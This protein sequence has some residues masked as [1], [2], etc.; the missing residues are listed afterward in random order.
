MSEPSDRFLDAYERMLEFLEVQGRAF[1]AAH[2]SV[3]GRVG[4]DGGSHADPLVRW[5]IESVAF[6][7]AATV[8]ECDRAEGRIAATLLERLAPWLVEPFPACGLAT[9]R[10]REGDASIAGG[11]VLPAGTVVRTAEP[12]ADG[13]RSLFR[14]AQDL[15][16]LPLEIV[17]AEVRTSSIDVARLPG[18]R[19]PAV[20]RLR[21]RTTAD[22]PVA[23]LSA[24]RLRLHFDGGVGRR[25]HHRLAVGAGPEEARPVAGDP[26][27]GWTVVEPLAGTG[28]DDDEALVPADPRV[29][30]GHRLLREALAMPARF[31]FVE[32]RG[33]G[34]AWATVPG[35]EIELVLPLAEDDPALE[36]RTTADCVH[37]HRVPI[38]NVVRTRLEP[39]RLHDRGRAIPLRCG[40]D[41]GGEIVRVVDVVGR[42]AGRRALRF[43]RFHDDPAGRE[44]GAWYRLER[45]PA[46][47]RAT[48]DDGDGDHRL[49]WRGSHC[50]LALVDRSA[51][52]WREELEA[53][54]V[55]AWCA[56]GLLP[57]RADHEGRRAL[58]PDASFPASAFGI[59]PGSIVPP[60]D[61]PPIDR[62]AWRLVAL[63][64]GD[65]A[66]AVGDGAGAT[67]RLRDLLLLHAPRRTRDV[68]AR[69]ESLRMVEI[70]PAT[71]PVIDAAGAS[72]VRGREC[73]LGFRDD[74]HAERDGHV[75]ASAIAAWLERTAPIDGFVRTRTM[76]PDPRAPRRA[77]DGVAAEV[78]VAAPDEVAA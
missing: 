50:R 21:L 43:H 24:D 28:T 6:V 31:R 63:V 59:V 15:E 55:D 1:A 36:A 48:D 13:R 42:G 5:L 8:L 65:V 18:G 4:L 51:A 68:L 57:C 23:A 39:S 12:D 54:H 9:C 60:A 29:N 53:L 30:G 70:V 3:A 7:N 32:V 38:A 20:L 69:I 47:D 64:T 72:L 14:T 56:Q 58:V 27:S 45:R 35:R 62:A 49:R 78:A 37:L 11:V 16:L 52:P 46:F 19:P 77:A 71:V 73:R 44:P 61:P 2:P 74:G 67:Q 66:D 26:E 75:L 34:P 76:A 33:L 41:A 22:V 17:A 10:P 40:D 25:L